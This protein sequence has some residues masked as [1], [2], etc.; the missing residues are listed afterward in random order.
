MRKIS[1]VIVVAMAAALGGCAKSP[2]SI[3]PSYISEVGYQAWS[4]PQLSEETL[5][6]SSAYA[7]AAQQQEKART[8]DVVGVILI[9]LPV[10][11]LSGDNIAPEIARL[12]GE[13]EAVRKAMVLKN[14]AAAAVPPPATAARASAKAPVAAVNIPAPAAAASAPAKK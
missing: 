5:R 10:S 2:E 9:G 11:S 3:A 12:K 6:L 4:C 13:Q 7:T 8:N 1:V 14:C